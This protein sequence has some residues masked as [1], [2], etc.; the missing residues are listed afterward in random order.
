M[1]KINEKSNKN[2][3]LFER[4]RHQVM[5]LVGI[6]VFLTV[7]E[8]AVIA[9]DIQAYLLPKPTENLSTRTPIRRATQKWPNS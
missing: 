4:L 9:L 1:E 5:P 7:W 6:L 3:Q 2:R 8:I